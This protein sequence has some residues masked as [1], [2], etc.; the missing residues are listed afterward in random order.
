MHVNHR[1]GE[2]SS[3][4]YR[5]RGG[6]WNKNP[7]KSWRPLKRR[8]WHVFRQHVRMLLGKKQPGDCLKMSRRGSYSDPSFKAPRRPRG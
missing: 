3:Q 1:R 4:N 2:T 8:A 7:G 6:K 5:R